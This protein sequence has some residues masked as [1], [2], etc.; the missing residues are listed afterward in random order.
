MWLPK[1]FAVVLY[2]LEMAAR[3]SGTRGKY[4]LFEHLLSVYLYNLVHLLSSALICIDVAIITAIA[5]KRCR[6]V[7]IVL[8]VVLISVGCVFVFV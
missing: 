6:L 2:A 1:I 4:G 8:T 7:V 5:E 3:R